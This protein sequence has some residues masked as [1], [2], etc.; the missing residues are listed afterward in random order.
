MQSR[1]VLCLLSSAFLLP[2]ALGV[3]SLSLRE[4]PGAALVFYLAA[5]VL[6][7]L[8]APAKT[9]FSSKS[10]ALQTWRMATERVFLLILVAA[11]SFL[12]SCPQWFLALLLSSTLMQSAA[13][14]IVRPSRL[15][16]PLVPELTAWNAYAQRVVPGIF[17]AD[18][19][20]ISVFPHAFVL[21]E[22]FHLAGY[23]FLASLQTLEV[24]HGFYQIRRTVVVWFRALAFQS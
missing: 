15:S 24:V 2:C 14:L 7:A 5:L 16:A 20:L 23:A 10:T 9:P 8:T 18:F 3:A 19:F 22:D 6:A 11:F 4:R 17:L 12:D 21:S 13:F 1:A